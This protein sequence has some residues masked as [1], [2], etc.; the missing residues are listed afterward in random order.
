MTGWGCHCPEEIQMSKS[1]W[2]MKSK[3]LNV[4]ANS[5]CHWDFELY[6]TFELWVLIDIVLGFPLRGLEFNRQ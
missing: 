4:K 1:K 3:C 5:F 6:L 2:Q